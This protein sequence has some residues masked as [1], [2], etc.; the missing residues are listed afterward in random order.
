MTYLALRSAKWQPCAC[1]RAAIYGNI[2]A[3]SIVQLTVTEKFVLMGLLF[4]F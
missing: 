3:G 2:P 4:S 1:K